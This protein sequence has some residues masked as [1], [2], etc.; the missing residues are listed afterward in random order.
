[1]NSFESGNGSNEELIKE[2]VQLLVKADNLSNVSVDRFSKR[3]NTPTGI[4]VYELWR[5]RL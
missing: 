1:M 3:F 2:A 4:Y 5:N